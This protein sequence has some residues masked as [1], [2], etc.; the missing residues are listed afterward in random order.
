MWIINKKY[1][2]LEL[3]NAFPNSLVILDKYVSLQEFANFCLRIN[4]FECF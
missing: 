2:A 1:V 4:A 3:Y